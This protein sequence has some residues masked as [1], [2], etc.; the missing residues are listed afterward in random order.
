[1]E[2][3]EVLKDLNFGERIAEE[4]ADQ[5]EHYFVETEQWRQ[6]LQGEK[7]IIYGMK[8][9]GKSALYTL[10]LKREKYLQGRKIYL[11]SAEKLQG[12]PVF[13][14]ITQEPPT[15]ERQFVGIWKAYFLQIVISKLQ[16]LE[17]KNKSLDSIYSYMEEAGLKSRAI[18]LRAFLELARN[19]IFRAMR[20]ES[21]ET[22]L[23]EG[24]ITGKITFGQ[25]NLDQINAGFMSIDDIFDIV[26]KVITENDIKLW[27]LLD[28]LDV[29]F[30][31]HP[32]LEKNALRAL[33]I[34]YSDFREYDRIK[35]KIFI[36]SDIWQRI[37]EEG[38]REASHIVRTVNISWDANSL[39]NLITK[40]LMQSN[41]LKDYL[42]IDATEVSEN[43]E[44]Q[45]EIFYEIFPNQ[46]DVG[47]KRPTTFD[48]ILRRTQDGTKLSAPREII[49]LV[50]EARGIQIRKSEIGE[51]FPER[52]ALINGISIKEALVEVS[53][54]R[55]NQTVLAE[56]SSMSQYIE[57]LRRQKT[58]QNGI[59]LSSIWS[60]KRDEAIKIAEQLVKIGFFEKRE[61]DQVTDYWVPFLYRDSLEMIQGAAEG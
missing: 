21:F 9:T 49:H 17:I 61:A 60:V 32:D 14:D 55:L 15:S 2:P 25:P 12:Q 46:V 27:I 29:A 4:E 59:S 26:N 30:S 39:L 54:T 53:R 11:M 22:T 52:E 36:R 31:E 43:I 50:S 56:Y 13:K 45:R 10:L 44:K 47:S 35:L 37:T 42:E 28:R 16:E 18:N 5:L 51:S 38:F 8:G 48:W 7:D 58:Q 1:M 24:G 20:P 19:F 40:R 3:L 33:F 23:G 57:K 6:I 34:T 41:M